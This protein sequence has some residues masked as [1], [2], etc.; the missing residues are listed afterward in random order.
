MKKIFLKVSKKSIALL[1]VF[2]MMLSLMLT[3]CDVEQLLQDLAT[4]F[5]QIEIVKNDGKLLAESE[6]NEQKYIYQIDANVTNAYALDLTNAVITLNMP[7]NVEFSKDG[8]DRSIKERK[9]AVEDMM[10]YSWIVKIPMIEED[11]NIEYS[12][13]IVSD[14]SNNVEA[15]GLLWVDG[16]NKDDNRL[17]FDVDTWKFKNYGEKPIPLTQEDYDALLHGFDNTTR[18]S[19]KDIVRDYSEDGFC[20][21]MAATTILTKMDRLSVDNIDSSA[22]NLHS[23]SKNDKAKS[24]IG[25]YWITQC[26]EVVGDEKATF[27]QKSTAEKLSIIEEKA[28]KVESGG[29]PFIFSFYSQPNGSGGHAVVGYSHERGSFE[30]NGTTYDSRI[31]IY[32]NNSPE[33]DERRCLYYNKG[34]DEWYIPYYS[35]A[36]GLTRALSDINI[37]DVKNIE[38]SS[39]SVNSYITARENEQL[40]IY[41]LDGTLL[42]SVNG[43]T[44]NNSESMVA[45]R[46][47]GVDDALVIAIPKKTNE[48]AFI[49]ESASDNEELNVSIK[50]DNYYLSASGNTEESIVLNPNGDVAINGKAT[51]FNI[52]ITANEGYYSTDWYQLSVSGD[53]GTNPKVEMTDK[54][55]ILSGEDLNDITVYAE[56]TETANELKLKTDED[57]VF[58]T[59]EGENLCVKS[60]EDQDGQYE[61]ILVTGTTVDPHDPTSGGPGFNLGSIFNFGSGFKFGGGSGSVDLWI[62]ILIAGVLLVS[63]ITTAIIV[64]LRSKKKKNEDAF[65]V[66]VIDNDESAEQ[67]ED[68]KEDTKV[69]LNGIQVLTGNMQGRQFELVDGKTYT[70]GKDSNLANILF[71]ASYNMVSRVHCTITYSAKFDKY[72]VIDCSSNGTFLQNGVR[73]AKNTRTPI[74]RGSIVKLA[75]DGCTIKLI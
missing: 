75:D 14:V 65:E 44:V 73:L 69:I 26:F 28:K 32:D 64:A 38:T 5:V 2:V 15:F 72:F 9:I 47:D 25:Y 61:T 54:G 37:M 27:M 3:G 48:E 23:V 60:D 55:Y 13:S 33:W 74:E 59:Q 4:D 49:V 39:K 66:P 53:S 40:N 51:D 16:K 17:N 70:I 29:T 20:Y 12:V 41:S 19:L 35:S 24:L 43:T 42:G 67:I 52:Q 30:W 63:V 36:S 58:I 68:E 57:T 6:E 46:Y 18:S 71:D 21:G 11:Q 56:N 31:L 62:I 34:T 8:D 7:D 10:S 45:F 1:M 50:Y 22:Q